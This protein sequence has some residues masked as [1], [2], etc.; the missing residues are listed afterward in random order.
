MTRVRDA[1]GHHQNGARRPRASAASGDRRLVCVTAQHRKMLDDLL[2][3]FAIAPE[4]DLNMMTRGSNAD[5]DN[6]PRARPEWNGCS[7]RRGRTSCSC[8]ATRRRARRRRSRR[9]TSKF[10][11]VT[12]RRACERNDRWLPYPE[13]MNRRLT[14][15]IASYHFAP[16]ALAR[17]H[18]LREHVDAADIVVTGNTVIDAF[19]ETARAATSAAAA[20]ERARSGASDR[21]RHRPPARESAVHARDLQ[22]DPRDRRAAAAAADILA[23]ASVA[24]RRADR[25]RNARRRFAA[26]YWSNR[27]TTREMVAAVKRCTFVLTDSGGLQEE[28][29]C[30]GKPVL[31]MREETERP[32]GPR[33]RHARAGR[34]RP[35]ANR[36]GGARGC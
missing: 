29:P 4:Y 21:G 10:R 3:L 15:T 11:S 16:T 9:S 35:Q 30:L 36:R 8:T 2:A 12:S 13:E 33:R 14:G 5:R 26:S 6:D 22:R 32:E 23:G 18:L 25:A 24:A 27:S 1:P 34:S 28:A 17:E 20:L 31:V 19:V 7:T